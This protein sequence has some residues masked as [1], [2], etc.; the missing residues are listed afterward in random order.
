MIHG[1][2]EP[3]IFIWQFYII[4]ILKNKANGD[5]LFAFNFYASMRN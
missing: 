4:P 3:I 2:G 5:Q 1:I